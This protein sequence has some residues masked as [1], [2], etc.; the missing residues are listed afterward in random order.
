MITIG[1]YIAIKQPAVYGELVCWESMELFSVARVRV[2]DRLRFG[3]LKRLME[4]RPKPGL[5]GLLP[6]EKAA[7]IPV[8]VAW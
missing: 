6:G 4:E 5:G 3:A 8:G 2:M 7:H 1:E